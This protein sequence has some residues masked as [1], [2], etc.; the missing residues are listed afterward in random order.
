MNLFQR[1]RALFSKVLK[2]VRTEIPKPITM[3]EIALPER[4]PTKVI[5]LSV[6]R[7]VPN[8]SSVSPSTRP[9]LGAINE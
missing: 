8:S 7:Q 5:F 4:L 2:T 9:V 6:I 3:E 1:A